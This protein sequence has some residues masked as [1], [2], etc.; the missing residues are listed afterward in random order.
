MAGGGCHCL[1]NPKTHYRAPGIYRGKIVFIGRHHDGPTSNV[2]LFFYT[3]RLV[4]A[5]INM[6]VS[7]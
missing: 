5:A 3:S 7:P 4:P 2:P 6:F 1:G